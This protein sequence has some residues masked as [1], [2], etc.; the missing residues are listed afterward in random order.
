MFA[1]S[2]SRNYINELIQKVGKWKREELADLY[3]RA[4]ESRMRNALLEP[5][6]FD[7]NDLGVVG[8]LAGTALTLAKAPMGAALII[9]GAMAGPD[10]AGKAGLC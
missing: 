4:R 1:Y 2:I 9:G 3:K 10:I 8:A 6:P 7:C 5:D